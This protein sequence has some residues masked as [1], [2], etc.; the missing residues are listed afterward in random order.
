MVELRSPVA[1]VASEDM[2]AFGGQPHC[3]LT[4]ESVGPGEPGPRKYFGVVLLEGLVHEAGTGR[5]V[6]QPAKALTN[7][8]V[9]GGGD[10]ARDDR[11]RPD[12]IE[13]HGGASH[14]LA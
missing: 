4:E 2:G 11:H 10:G 5:R 1:F 7:L 12:H 6:A 9:I 14:T 13:P 3:Q 8:R